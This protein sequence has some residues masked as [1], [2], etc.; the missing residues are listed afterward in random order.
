MNQT[1]I[2]S[3]QAIAYELRT[4]NMIAY[5][6]MNENT[7]GRDGNFK[8]HDENLSQAIKWRIDN[9]PHAMPKHNT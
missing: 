6:E 9:A 5:L 7:I 2:E 1:M 8:S 4:A 3:L